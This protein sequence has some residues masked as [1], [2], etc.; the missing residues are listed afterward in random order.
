VLV[1]L[2]SNE[3]SAEHEEQSDTGEN[4]VPATPGRIAIGERKN[5][6]CDCPADDDG[7]DTDHH[8]ASVIVASPSAIG[9]AS[10]SSTRRDERACDRMLSAAE[11]ALDRSSDA[12]SQS[13]H[14]TADHKCLVRLIPDSRV[15][16]ESAL[17]DGAI[18]GN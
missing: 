3:H 14:V 16:V 5:S 2:P 10:T 8:H 6:K 9:S 17:V 4:V 7:D 13:E 15:F 12:A 1:R 11:P 18:D